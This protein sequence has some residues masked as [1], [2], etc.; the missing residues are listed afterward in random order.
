M[1]TSAYFDDAP[2]DFAAVDIRSF[3]QLT[4]IERS[5]GDDDDQSPTTPAT[6]GT[7]DGLNDFPAFCSLSA[8]DSC[9]NVTLSQCEQCNMSAAGIWITLCLL[10]G[11]ATVLGNVFVILLTIKKR[12]GFTGYY[13]KIR[14]SLAIA[15]LLAGRQLCS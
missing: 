4:N 9:R 7:S 2:E 5:V 1:N 15:D 6:P 13:N 12:P 3:V 11:T 8:I 10:I 14:A